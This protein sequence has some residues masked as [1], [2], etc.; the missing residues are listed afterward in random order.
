MIV[1]MFVVGYE[2]DVVDSKGRIPE[3][4]PIPNYNGQ[5]QVC[6]TLA[7]LKIGTVGLLVSDC[8][9]TTSQDQR[10]NNILSSSSVSSSRNVHM[11]SRHQIYIIFNLR[12]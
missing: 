12:L 1:A 8:I 3:R 11:E 7:F 10:E 6:F 2:Y 5:H 9:F 4:L